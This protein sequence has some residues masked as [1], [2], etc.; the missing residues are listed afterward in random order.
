M[1]MNSHPSAISRQATKIP[2]KQSLDSSTP[3]TP[4]RVPNPVLRALVRASCLA[5]FLVIFSIRALCQPTIPMEWFP[6]QPASEWW[7][8]LCTSY[9]SVPFSFS[10]NLISIPVGVD[11]G[12]YN[13]LILDSTNLTPAYLEYAVQD[14]NGVE[15]FSYYEG[16]ALFYYCPNWTSASLENGT[17]PGEAAYLLASGDWSSGSPNGL[18]SIYITADGSSLCVAGVG[19]GVTNIYAMAAIAWSSNTFHQVGVE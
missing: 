2:V 13:E 12:I 17:G 1:K 15:N 3:R 4:R 6:F 11:F 5:G 10:T 9:G 19:A 18:F 7:P 8:A 16:T 14:S